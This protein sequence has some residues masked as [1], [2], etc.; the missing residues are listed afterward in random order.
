V[1][2]QELRK[3]HIARTMTDDRSGLHGETTSW[4]LS[5]ATPMVATAAWQKPSAATND[6]LSSDRLL[7]IVAA[8]SVRSN[9]SSRG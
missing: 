8:T 7:Q 4:G 9:S 5:T 1:S 3:T 2:K 6:N